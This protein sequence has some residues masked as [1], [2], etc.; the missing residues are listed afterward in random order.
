[1]MLLISKSKWP[2]TEKRF[3]TPVLGGQPPHTAEP[4]KPFKLA[5]PKTA[6][7]PCPF[8]PSK[9]TAQACAHCSPISLLRHA[10][11]WWGLPPPL[12]ICENKKCL[13]NGSHLLIYWSC[14]L[15]NNNKIYILKHQPPYPALSFSNTCIIP[16]HI[17]YLFA[18]GLSFSTRWPAPWGYSSIPSL[19]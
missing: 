6:Y 10:S 8:L 15:N 4:L 2:L 5:S 7:L 3:P 11:P 18:C 1:M 16:Q 19:R 17:M 13:F 9:T 12:G 14:H